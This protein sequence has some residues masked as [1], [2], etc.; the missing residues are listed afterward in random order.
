[1]KA[2]YGLEGIYSNKS[3]LALIEDGYLLKA[4]FWKDTVR[5][6]YSYFKSRVEYSHLLSLRTAAQIGLNAGYSSQKICSQ[7]DDCAPKYSSFGS[8]SLHLLHSYSDVTTFGLEASKNYTRT[9]SDG[10]RSYDSFPNVG[11]FVQHVSPNLNLK[12][13]FVLGQIQDANSQ[14][15]SA[16]DRG[17]R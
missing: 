4:L 3:N 14:L 1:K 5:P 11:A 6:E 12:V 13:G 17:Q 10:V 7:L 9:E 15:T 2:Y 16:E 8:F